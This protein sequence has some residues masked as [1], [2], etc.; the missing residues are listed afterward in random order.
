MYWRQRFVGRIQTTEDI[1]DTF[2]KAEE[3]EGLQALLD[4]RQVWMNVSPWIIKEAEQNIT[5]N[6]VINDNDDKETHVSILM[7][8]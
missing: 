7:W 2:I 4:E 1:N 6:T 5:K 3:N 8:S